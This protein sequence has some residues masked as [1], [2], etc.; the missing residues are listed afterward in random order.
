MDSQT[1]PAPGKPVRRARLAIA[2]P[3]VVLVLTAGLVAWSA[4]PVLRPAQSVRVVQAVF[5]RA[6]AAAEPPPDAP[7]GPPVPT[8][9]MVQAAGWLEAEPYFIACTA[10][11]DGIVESI[12][13]LEG[14][15][16]EAG[17]VVARLVA[18]D[19]TLRLR[20][21]E[22]ELGA[23][24]AAL[25]L[26]RAHREAAQTAWDQPVE[27]ERAVEA[28]TAAL[29]ESRAELRQ[30]PHLI[31]AARQ[32]LI[33]HEEEHTRLEQSRQTQAATELEV[34]MARQRAAAQ[35]AEVEALKAR[36][37]LLT[38][39]VERLEAELR[40]ARRTLDLRVDDR[41]RLQAAL[42]QVSQAE[43]A[44][45]RAQAARD[46]AALELERMVIRAPVGGRVQRRL[47]G[48]GDKVV[49]Q[50]D[51]PLSLHLVHLYDPD[52]LQV[53]VDVPLADAGG[54]VEG[55]RCEVVVEVLPD[56]VFA[57]HV[58]R[59]THEA[60]VQKNTLQVKVDIE[61]PSP[62]L[63]PE[64]LT[65]VKFLPGAVGGP[66]AAGGPAPAAARV[67][68]PEAALDTRDGAARVWVVTDRREGGG[69]L[70]QVEVAPVAR[71]AGWVRV[72]GPL[73]P[74]ALLAVAEGPLADG[75]PVRIEGPWTEAKP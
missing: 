54:I 6:A 52:A 26:A 4:W 59:I 22:A 60:D 55:Q 51:N 32:T 24:Q 53:R 69:V 64:M 40:A 37:P 36:E 67:L 20:Q 11:A 58:L 63:R 42:S 44:L 57:G 45:A 72:E 2:V 5:D 16:V 70:R 9:A 48:P 17:Q 61:D 33:R 34:I 31:D 14:D 46:E 49:R 71:S 66:S 18:D 21:A 43:A 73:Q 8:G 56:R 27:L 23:A 15:R 12:H 3:V 41:L 62:L 35:R 19:A 25:D 75:Q 30:L 50:A 38:A 68:V 29:A 1:A 10:L 65:R 7:A 47:K 13:V 39:R 28:T 74:G